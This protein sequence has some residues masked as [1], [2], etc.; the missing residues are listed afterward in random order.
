MFSGVSRLFVAAVIMTALSNSASAVQIVSDA[1]PSGTSYTGTLDAFS[2][3]TSYDPDRATIQISLKNTTQAQVGGALTSFA[4]NLPDPA[5]AVAPGIISFTASGTGDNNQWKAAYDAT[6][7][8]VTFDIGASTHN[9]DGGNLNG[10]KVAAGIQLGKT[11]SFT[12][13]F[14]G[15][16]L[17]GLSSTDFVGEAFFGR[18]QGITGINGATSSKVDGAFINS[19]PEPSTYAFVLSGLAA[20]GLMGLRR[21]RRS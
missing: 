21:R 8:S 3:D 20:A 16:D 4:F 1:H 11:A 6:S 12:I 13:T 9:N 2:V 17:A 14:T 10:G 15:T 7:G 5:K 19:V 18:F